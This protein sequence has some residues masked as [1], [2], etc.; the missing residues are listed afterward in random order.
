MKWHVN[1]RDINES[2]NSNDPENAT[3]D[4]DIL[5]GR[6][7]T[8]DELEEMIESLKCIWGEQDDSAN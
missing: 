8:F 6:V 4:D 3:A 5:Q 7:K 1:K 2:F